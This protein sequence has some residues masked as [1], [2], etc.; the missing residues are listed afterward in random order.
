MDNVNVIASSPLFD[1]EWYRIKYGIGNNAAEHYLKKGWK[2]GFDPS[3]NFSS[4]DY[5]EA[6]PDVAAAKM[7]PLLHYELYGR[8]EGRRSCSRFKRITNKCN[9]NGRGLEIG[10][11]IS[12][13]VPKKKG[14][15]VEILDHLDRDG[16]IEKYKNHPNVGALIDNIEEVDYVWSGE[17]YRELIG[18][19]DYYNY[20]IAS[21]VIEHTTDFIG[22]F[23]QCA[24]LLKENGVLSLVIPNKRY[25]F[26][27]FRENTSISEVIEKQTRECAVHGVSKRIDYFTNVVRLDDMISWNQDFLKNH[28]NFSYIYSKNDIFNLSK[29]KEFIDIH[30]WVFTPGSFRIL[31]NDLWELGYINMREESFYSN[32]AENTCEFYM[33]LRKDTSEVSKRE[34]DNNR[35]LKL[36]YYKILDEISFYQQLS[37]VLKYNEGFKDFNF[38]K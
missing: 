28:N 23:I 35:R 3:E 17:D 37:K 2:K 6:N 7:C 10:P 16:L 11:S 38:Q 26:D 18:K 25:S 36:Q 30:E 4:Q 9:L 24:G 5:L 29:S 22:F 21:H 31:I 19:E 27:F 14:Y 12:P 13:I 20:I 8:E 15:N 34:F 33:S 32:A 1:S